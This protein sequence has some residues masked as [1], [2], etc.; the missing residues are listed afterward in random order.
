[1]LYVQLLQGLRKVPPDEGEDDEGEE[2][3]ADEAA[4][5]KQI[6]GWLESLES[7]DPMRKGRYRD[8]GMRSTQAAS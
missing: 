8:L 3:E 4:E 7:L 1:M 2:E 6:L 5:N